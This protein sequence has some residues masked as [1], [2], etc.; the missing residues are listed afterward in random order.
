VVRRRN[1]MAEDL[2]AHTDG[3]EFVIE[4]PV[5]LSTVRLNVD[6]AIWLKTRLTTFVEDHAAV[7]R[8]TIRR[9]EAKLRQLEAS[10]PSPKRDAHIEALKFILGKGF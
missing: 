3:A 4:L 7:D 1:D 6:E 9:A 5:K 2:T 8:A 10:E